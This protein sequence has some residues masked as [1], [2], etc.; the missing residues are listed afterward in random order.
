MLMVLGTLG[1]IV[2]GVSIPLF[3]V[4]FGRIIDELNKNPNGFTEAINRLCLSFLVVAC[5]NLFS[6]FLQVYPSPIFR[7][8]T[9]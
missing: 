4:L 8:D 1:G 9:Q 5:A 2:T 7:L 3:N 6:G